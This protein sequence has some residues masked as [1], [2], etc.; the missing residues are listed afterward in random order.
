MKEYLHLCYLANG[1]KNNDFYLSNRKTG[2]PC[3]SD[4]QGDRRK[5]WT[6]DTPLG[7][8]IYF[9]EIKMWMISIA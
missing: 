6:Q 4:G 3:N 9:Q 8:Y 7:A 1:S 5:N 2:I